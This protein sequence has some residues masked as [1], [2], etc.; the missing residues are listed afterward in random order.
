[1]MSEIGSLQDAVAALPENLPLRR[2]L[3]E[4][5]EKAQRFD[6]ALEQHEAILAR[7]A[8]D[9]PALLGSARCLYEVGNYPEALARYDRAVAGSVGLA[10]ASLRDRILKAQAD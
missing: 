9:P 8:N 7:A 10:D 3:A 4:E 5:L 1:D 6:E 2:Q